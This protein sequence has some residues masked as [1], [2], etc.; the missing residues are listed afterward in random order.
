[1]S[2]K[3][4]IAADLAAIV[5]EV[6]EAVTWNGQPYRALVSDPTIG[7]HLELGG[8]VGTGDFTTNW[9]QDRFL[10]NEELNRDFSVVEIDTHG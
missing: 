9:V 10:P 6:G 3:D 5:A 8:F 4:E 1:M 2:I 7:E